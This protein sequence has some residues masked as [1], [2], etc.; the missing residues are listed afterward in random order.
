MEQPGFNRVLRAHTACAAVVGTVLLL[1]PHRA[2]GALSGEA[3]SHF[4]HEV[5]RCYGALTLAQAWFAHR[6]VNIQ[7]ARVRKMLAES[8]AVCYA[9]TG[10][11]LLRACA[12]SPNT[13]GAFGIL[14]TLTAFALAALYAFFRF[15][16]TIKSFELP[17]SNH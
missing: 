7:D 9:F 15:V 1:L 17:G 12:A 5:A 8:Y 3:Y 4:G 2:F 10:L 6:T 11:A 16:R 14:A 13:T